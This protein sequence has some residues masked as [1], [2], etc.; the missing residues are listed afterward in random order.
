MP[1]LDSSPN[2]ENNLGP[3]IIKIQKAAKIP[4]LCSLADDLFY[5][6]MAGR[7]GALDQVVWRHVANTPHVI[8]LQIPHK[9]SGCSTN[10]V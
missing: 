5:I 4:E 3:L 10:H 8:E 6:L 2:S 7:A 1:N 9:A